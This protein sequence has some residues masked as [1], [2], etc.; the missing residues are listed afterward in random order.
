MIDDNEKLSINEVP[1]VL[2]VLELSAVQL[3]SICTLI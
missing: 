1:E 3:V 2:L